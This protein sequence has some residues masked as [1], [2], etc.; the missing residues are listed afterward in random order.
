MFS[1]AE[2]SNLGRRL[3]AAFMALYGGNTLACASDMPAVVSTLPRA[4]PRQAEGGG[5]LLRPL[6]STH[7]MP[8]VCAALRGGIRIA[9]S[10]VVQLVQGKL[11]TWALEAQKFPSSHH[12]GLPAD[13]LLRKPYTSTGKKQ[14][15]PQSN[16][17]R[18]ELMHVR[19]TAQRLLVSE[20]FDR[21]NRTAR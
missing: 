11:A 21:R 8:V 12:V 15:S 19:C 18:I 16:C 4:N 2:Y 9:H 17:I 14:T 10:N 3:G 13:K 20:G 1:S 7:P 5:K 6:E